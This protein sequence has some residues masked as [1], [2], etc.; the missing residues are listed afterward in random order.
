MAAADHSDQAQARLPPG[1]ASERLFDR[2]AFY[3]VP[4]LAGLVTAITLFGPGSERE[5]TGARAYGLLVENAPRWALRIETLGHAQSRYRPIELD[6]VRV[7][8]SQGGTALGAWT[9]PSDAMGI[10]DA[11]GTLAQP[12]A[13]S[14]E[15]TIHAAGRLL[16]RGSFT[17]GP[18]LEPLPPVGPLEGDTQGPVE[19]AVRIPRGLAIASLPET[20]VIEVTVATSAAEPRGNGTGAAPTP[21]TLTMSAAGAD[22]P[23]ATGSPEAECSAEHCRYAWSVPIVPQAP[24]A[25][26]SVVATTAS[27]AIGRW[28]GP[29]PVTLGGLWLEPGA[30]AQGT[31]LIRS[32]SPQRRA[33][34]SLLSTAGRFWGAGLALEPNDAGFGQGS[35]PLPA[36]GEGPIM[37]VLSSDPFEPEGATS[38][39]PLRPEQG[40]LR[41]ERPR[42]LADSMPAAIAEERGRRA[43]AR[44]PAYG[45]ILTA[46]LFELAFLLRRYRLTRAR[47]ARYIE[48]ASALQQHDPETPSAER[49]AAPAFGLAMP[50]ADADEA[51]LKAEPRTEPA[52][53]N[54][55]KI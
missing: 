42:L 26:L 39:W 10:A 37:V 19:V 44:L 33:Y 38:G 46:A 12:V 22:L 3:G 1:V 49:D 34:V 32:P 24:D 8:L 31:I 53:N 25:A 20:A 35:V 45:L 50:A 16:G 54:E 41:L 9:G 28:Q 40:V 29:I 7:E 6:D 51:A 11:T 52:S 13:G 14:V 36:V 47:L 5:A 2:I 30:L 15:L 18:A 23:A 17:L 27:G 4:C 55:F 43:R 48:A 21:P